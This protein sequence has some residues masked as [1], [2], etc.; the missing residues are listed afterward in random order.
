MNGQRKPFWFRSII[1]LTS[2]SASI[3]CSLDPKF[4]VGRDMTS[5]DSKLLRRSI[6]IFAKERK[7]R[8]RHP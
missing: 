3:G 4:S 1:A 8:Q 5:T 6:P 2:E 7:V